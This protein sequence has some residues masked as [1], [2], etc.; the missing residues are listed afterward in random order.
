MKPELRKFKK[1]SQGFSLIELLLASSLVIFMI[2]ASAQ[3]LLHALEAR[4]HASDHLNSLR[5][6]MTHL[7]TLKAQPY[8]S[9]ELRAGSQSTII[10]DEFSPYTYEFNWEI[11]EVSSEIKSI[12]TE[13][14]E[15][16]HP[17]RRTRVLLYVSRTLGF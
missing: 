6:V 14:R 12:F 4:K 11:K 7:E 15:L 17:Q 16:N 9:P 1:P 8:D 5:I 3:L 13:C 2:L 10:N